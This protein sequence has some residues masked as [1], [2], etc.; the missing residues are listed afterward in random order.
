MTGVQ[1]CALPIF[2]LR[3]GFIAN[4]EIIAQC[5]LDDDT[6]VCGI[7]NAIGYWGY[8]GVFGVIA[9][10]ISTIALFVNNKKFGII[11]LFTSIFAI[12]MFNTYVGSIAFILILMILCKEE[13]LKALNS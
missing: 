8:V 10:I 2:S 1:T 11:A 12:M 5:H 9:I 3:Y 6:L 13:N 4:K 7:K